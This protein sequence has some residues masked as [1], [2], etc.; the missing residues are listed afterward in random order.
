MNSTRVISTHKILPILPIFF[1]VINSVHE[2][3]L[4][5]ISTP[6]EKGEPEECGIVDCTLEFAIEKCPK[7]CSKDEPELCKVADCQKPISTQ[8]C[9][10][11]CGSGEQKEKG[12]N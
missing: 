10:K 11:T 7:T 8:F 1:H 12:K 4:R 3:N 2:D 5:S 6:G 9:P